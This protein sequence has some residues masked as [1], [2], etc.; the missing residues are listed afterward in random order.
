MDYTC[1]Q[2]RTKKGLATDTY[3][4]YLQR[5]LEEGKRE[6]NAVNSQLGYEKLHTARMASVY[7]LGNC[8][9]ASWYNKGTIILLSV[10]R[11]IIPAVRD[12]APFELWRATGRRLDRE[13]LTTCVRLPGLDGK[14][15]L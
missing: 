1:G 13:G 5:R 15:H 3:Q 14:V 9:V 7:Q 11:F 12:T 10:L 8:R 4:H 2:K 6:G